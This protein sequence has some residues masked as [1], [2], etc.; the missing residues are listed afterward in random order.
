MDYRMLKPAVSRDAS[1]RLSVDVF[2]VPLKLYSQ[3]CQEITVAFNL[4]SDGKLVTN[5]VDIAFKDFNSPLGPV[6]MAWDNWSGF[7]VTAM[8]HESEPI[9][10][11]IYDWFANLEINHGG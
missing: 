8:T 5:A 2:D 9:I 6:Q 10:E 3:I 7:T 11:R 4:E 1:G